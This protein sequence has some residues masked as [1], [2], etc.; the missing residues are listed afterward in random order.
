MIG[1]RVA[2]QGSLS[3]S[4]GALSRQTRYESEEKMRW[5]RRS[6]CS[7]TSNPHVL[8]G[9]EGKGLNVRTKEQKEEDVGARDGLEVC[10]EKP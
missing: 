10:R 1:V 7:L 4:A 5:R 2:N 9:L 8:S 3:Q 6:C